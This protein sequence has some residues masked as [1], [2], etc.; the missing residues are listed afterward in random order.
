MRFTS[1]RPASAAVG[2]RGSMSAETPL[3][4]SFVPD[5]DEKANDAKTLEANDQAVEDDLE[6]EVIH[7][8]PTSRRMSRADEDYKQEGEGQEENVDQ[9]VDDETVPDVYSA[10]ILAADEVAKNPEAEYMQPAVPPEWERSQSAVYIDSDENNVL[11][12]SNSRNNSRPNS[13]PTSFH[14]PTS[15][16]A[17]PMVRLM[18]NDEHE[19][20]STPLEEIHEYEPLF[21][22]DE[23]EGND[24]GVKDREKKMM[25]TAQRPK[26]DAHSHRFPS[27]DIWEDTPGSL[28]LQTVVATPQLPAEEEASAAK[29][30]A[31]GVFESPE[32]EKARKANEGMTDADRTS[33][34]PQKAKLM[35]DPRFK[36]GVREEMDMQQQDRPGNSGS[37]RPGMHPRFPSRDVW[38]DSP[39]HSKLVTTVQNPQE[40]EEIESATSTTAAGDRFT[41]NPAIPPRPPRKDASSQMQDKEGLKDT[42]KERAQPALPDRPKPKLPTRPA[43]LASK[44]S[45]EQSPLSRTMSMGSEE[46]NGSSTNNAAA[47]GA[48]SG[49][50]NGTSVAAVKTK[51]SLPPWPGNKIAAL[52]A[53]FMS[54][55]NSKLKMGPAAVMSRGRESPKSEDGEGVDGV[56]EK[57]KDP[58][59]DV[60]KGRAKGPARRKPAAVAAAG[61]T[62][63][64]L[65]ASSGKKEEEVLLSISA[66]SVVWRLDVHDD[67]GGYGKVIVPGLDY[68]KTADVT[69]S[70]PQDARAA[71]ARAKDT[72]NDD[73]SGVNTPGTSTNTSSLARSID[74][75]SSKVQDADAPLMTSTAVQTGHVD[76][77]VPALG[78]GGSGRDDDDDDRG[79]NGNGNGNGDAGGGRGDGREKMTVYIG[80]AAPEEGNVVVKHGLD[81]TGDGDVE[82]DGGGNVDSSGGGGGGD[83]GKGEVVGSVKKSDEVII[84]D[85]DGEERVVKRAGEDV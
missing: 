79:G 68:I 80:G 76:I 24:A 70:P 32:A 54:D 51:P 39:D 3:R 12:R 61:A 26:L 56:E 48:E 4:Q 46:S 10:P 45:S 69:S 84:E 37:R 58:M 72:T 17:N 41:A 23:E 74:L 2:K 63:G 22:S 71:A 21:P 64:G 13:R 34:L 81:G 44:E 7:I 43:R 40:R 6:D 82:R 9:D 1:P 19:H 65:T 59:K 57:E 52:K 49:T 11:R 27:M 8:D 16:A 66:A 36:P 42:S 78:H 20:S 29:K 47:A 53:G 25:K 77:N 38:E 85:A 35:A 83:D 18:N 55:L 50:N 5:D 15:G 31:A 60:R 75:K 67:D 28:Q 73:T 30:S 62:A 14:A 33:F